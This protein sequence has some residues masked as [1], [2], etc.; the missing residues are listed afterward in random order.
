M[1][2][3][4][5]TVV[6]M[7]ATA[8]QAQARPCA[9][10][11]VPDN[12][13]MQAALEGLDT[14]REYATFVETSTKHFEFEQSAH[15]P[16]ES[17]TKE[18]RF[19]VAS[20]LNTNIDLGSARIC[21]G[22]TSRGSNSSTGLL[23]AM[24]PGQHPYPKVTISGAG[25]HGLLE[26]S[27]AEDDSTLSEVDHTGTT[28]LLG[29]NVAFSEWFSLAYTRGFS[30]DKDTSIVELGIPRYRFSTR[31]V[32]Q[33]KLQVIP[34]IGFHDIRITNETQASIV[35]RRRIGENRVNLIP[36]LTH[37]IGN[38][39]DMTLNAEL[40]TA[41]EGSPNGFRYTSL[42]FVNVL[43]SAS[44]TPIRARVE[45]YAAISVHHGT[46]MQ[47]ASEVSWAVG[48]EYRAMIGFQSEYIYFFFDFGLS[49]NKPAI[50][51]LRPHLANTANVTTGMNL[52]HHW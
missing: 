5:F 8:T 9:E 48:G 24:T 27:P 37:R 3:I 44:T 14:L 41:F 25:H 36:T 49:I 16:P 51:D 12:L 38:V 13:T 17:Q 20:F 50:L 34:D 21:P 23:V 4:V 32:Y 18:A 29:A 1:R 7:A 39:S 28:I 10:I 11:V 31:L 42:K 2:T 19:T 45:Q 30:S 26:M 15:A 43:A 6:A 22:Y 40:E 47:A 35:L 33:D 46:E 52:A